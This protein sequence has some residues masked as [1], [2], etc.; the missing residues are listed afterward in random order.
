M[1]RPL[2]A[3]N[4][5]VAAL[6]LLLAMPA[7][8]AAPSTTVMIAEVYGGGGRGCHLDPETSSSSGTQAQPPCP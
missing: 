8:Q 3:I 1:H 5:A 2:T 4:L 7:A 6:G